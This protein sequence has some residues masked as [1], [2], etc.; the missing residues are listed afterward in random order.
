MLLWNNALCLVKIA[1]WLTYL[2]NQRI[3]FQGRVVTQLKFFLMTSDPW[4]FQ[5]RIEGWQGSSGRGYVVMDDLFITQTSLKS[6]KNASVT[7]STSSTST[8][9]TTTTASTTTKTSSTSK[10]TSKSLPFPCYFPKSSGP[11]TMD[12]SRYYFDTKTS[13]CRQ[14]TYG[15]CKGNANNFQSKAACK[16]RCADKAGSSAAIKDICSLPFSEGSC[17]G[18]FEK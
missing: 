1:T 9:S 7:T 12:V 14:F 15:G 5:I 18:L 6:V 8:T 4:S 10:T 11:C 16:A 17:H 13:A 3:L 2:I